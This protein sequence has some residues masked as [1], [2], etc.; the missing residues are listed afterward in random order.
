L[1]DKYWNNQ[2]PEYVVVFTF[3]EAVKEKLF[4]QYRVSNSLQNAIDFYR[5]QRTLSKKELYPYQKQAIEEFCANNFA[6]FYEMATGTGKTFTAIKTIRE[7]KQRVG[8]KVYV[9]ICVP[10]IDLQTQWEKALNEEGYD[11]VYLFGGNGNDSDRAL[12][13]Q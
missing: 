6:H 9:M 8:T 13:E 11:R 12:S 1:F 10:Q 7:L 3:P 5:K 2:F 4:E